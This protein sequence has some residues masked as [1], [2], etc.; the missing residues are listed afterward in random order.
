MTNTIISTL[1]TILLLLIAIWGGQL[2]ASKQK[3]KTTHRD[4]LGR[5]A[6]KPKTKR[7]LR[8][9]PINYMGRTIASFNIA[10]R[11]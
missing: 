7:A 4:R 10:D 11:F 5:Y 8:T 6:N 3:K 9:I 2:K 1:L